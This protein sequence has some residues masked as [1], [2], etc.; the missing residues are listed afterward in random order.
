M[1]FLEELTEDQLWQEFLERKKEQKSLSPREEQELADYVKSRRYKKQAEEIRRGAAFP[2]PEKHRISKTGTDKKRTVYEFSGDFGYL[3][4]MAAWRLYRYDGIFAD[5]L[6]SFRSGKTVRQGIR[7][8]LNGCAGHEWYSCKVDIHNYFNS[9]PVHRLL[10]MLENIFGKDTEETA[11]CRRLLLDP[12]AVFG[13]KI[14]CEEKGA[15]AGMPLSAFFANV[16]LMELDAWF[17]ERKILY[18]RY[19]DDIIVFAEREEQ[20]REYRE[21]I[22]E[23]IRESGL[24]FNPEKVEETAPG[25]PW[26]FLG[27]KV[28]GSEVDVAPISVKK[29]KK[30][31]KR[32]ADALVR[33]KKRKGASGE[34]AARAFIRCFNRK[35]FENPVH[36]ELTWCRW[37]FPLITTDKSLRVI[38]HYM[39]DCVRYVF[40][41]RHS[42]AGYNLRY[43]TMKEYGYRPL[44]AAYYE[45]PGK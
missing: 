34:R 43:E 4:K 17:E 36:S 6:W 24:T 42:K 3:L 14:V 16:Y 38:D 25:E 19:S 27:V 10:P 9:I 1:G 35:F 20:I 21:R 8:L 2:I 44:T 39:Q 22:T 5:N 28:R 15:M 18:A 29:I 41:G 23:F 7:H 37:Y 11:F 40:L 33:W 45:L 31:M 13:G 32:K 26:C 12:R 30:K